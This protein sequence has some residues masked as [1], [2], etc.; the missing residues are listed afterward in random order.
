MTIIRAPRPAEGYTVL[1]NT[2]LRDQRLSWKARGLL[3]YLLSLPDNWRTNSAHLTRMAPDGR[4]SVLSGLRELDD[5]G[6]LRRQR[7]QDAAGRW[8]TTVT[9]YDTPHL[10]TTL[11]T[12]VGTADSPGVDSPTSDNLTPYELPEELINNV[13][14]LVTRVLCPHCSGSGLLTA[15]HWD[16]PSPCWSCSGEGTVKGTQP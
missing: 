14:D 15:G 16:D 5:H 10:W 8:S 12:N 6:Y 13:G 9:V 7:K 2:T 4:A 3:A 11:G 1:A